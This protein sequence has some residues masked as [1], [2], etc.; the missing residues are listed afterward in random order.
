MRS[1]PPLNTLPAFEATARLGSV[2][3]AAQELNRTHGAVS[4]QLKVLSEALGYSLFENHGNRLVLTAQGARFMDEVAPSLDRLANAFEAARLSAPKSILRLGVSATFASRWLMPRLPQFYNVHPGIEIEFKMAGRTPANLEET[5]IALTWDRLRYASDR[6][7]YES[8]GDVHFGVVHAPGF[9]A[10]ARGTAYHVTTRLVPDTLPTVWDV[11]GKL[12]G[13]TV[14]GDRDATIPQ[15]GLIID[16]ACNGMGAAVI[17]RRLVEDALQDERLVAP[18][19]W[20]EIKGGFGCYLTANALNKPE[21]MA[22]V[23]W[24]RGVV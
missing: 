20:T 6:W 8:I 16:M 2:T 1:L 22:F 15:T 11:W 13:V 19:G 3:K 14:T 18:F 23:A 24:L 10:T 4:K 17:E 12:S 9:A 5:D 21:V 7:P